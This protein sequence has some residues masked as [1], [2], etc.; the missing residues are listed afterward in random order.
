MSRKIVLFGA[1]KSSSYAIEYLLQHAAELNASVTV[2]DQNVTHLTQIFGNHPALNP[3]VMDVKN[4]DSER[5]SI[6]QQADIVLSLLP[7]FLHILV[8]KDC[9]QFEKDLITAS[10]V[11]E[12]IKA[13]HEEAKSKNILFLCEMGLDPGIDHMSA[14]QIIH[15][16]KHKNCSIHSFKSHCGGLVSPENDTNPWHYKISWNPRN[17]VTAGAAGAQYIEDKKEVKIE[18]KNMFASSHTIAVDGLGELA[19]YPNRD[20]VSYQNLYELEKCNTLIRTTL[21]YPSFIKAWHYMVNLGLTTEQPCNIDTT[22]LSYKN[23]ISTHLE[24]TSLAEKFNEIFKEDTQSK[25]LFLALEFD[26]TVINIGTNKCNADILQSLIE[27]RWAM[28]TDDKDMIVMQHEFDYVENETNKSLTSSI[29]VKGR[30]KIF[31]AMAKTV[32]LPMA[33]GAKLLLNKTIENI[34]GVQI[35]IHK[36]IYEPVL[37]ELQQH[38]IIFNEKIS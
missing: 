38:G 15:E 13:L 29:V 19:Y 31:T 18:Y 34:T 11:S 12:E 14:M 35:P 10:Y 30:D 20:S 3:V 1:G 16:L 17:V 9:L 37:K 36:E 22:T 4:N 2:I 8:A 24:T 25:D 33:I 32:G 5:K 28:Q 21:R 7:P 26:D 23:W 6:I 27:K